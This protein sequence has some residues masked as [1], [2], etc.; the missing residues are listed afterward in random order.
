MHCRRSRT[1]AAPYPQWG[2]SAQHAHRLREFAAEARS[3]ASKPFCGA[4]LFLCNVTK[5]QGAKWQIWTGNCLCTDTSETH[6]ARLHA[7]QRFPWTVSRD[8]LLASNRQRQA[9]IQNASGSDIY[10]RTAT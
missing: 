1:R 5:E 8:G 6:T 10:C 4:A 9:A 7:L 3:L 2:G